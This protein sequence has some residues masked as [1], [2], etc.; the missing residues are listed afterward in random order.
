MARDRRANASGSFFVA[1]VA[2]RAVFASFGALLVGPLAHGALVA[3]ARRR[4]LRVRTI[5]VYYHAETVVIPRVV[6]FVELVDLVLPWIAV[7]TQLLVL[8][9][10]ELQVTAAFLAGWDSSPSPQELPTLAFTAQSV[11]HPRELRVSTHLALSLS[12]LVREF[13]VRAEKEDS[14]YDKDVETLV[15]GRPLLTKKSK[16]EHLRGT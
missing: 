12:V 9:T 16:L 7:G 3:L 1:P 10:V 14:S 4:L 13:A 8:L 6:S 11:F 15:V 2:L 5:L